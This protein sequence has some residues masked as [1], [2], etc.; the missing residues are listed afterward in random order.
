M[1]LAPKDLFVDLVGNPH[2]TTMAVGQV[3]DRSDD[4]FDVLVRANRS[5]ADDEGLA[6][7]ARWPEG[8][9]VDSRVADRGI[10]AIGTQDHLPRER[11]EGDEPVVG[12]RVCDLLANLDSEPRTRAASRSVAI[13]PDHPGGA[14]AHG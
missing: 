4:E 10:G 8:A 14:A 12:Q 13:R 3:S 11:R 2:E 6:V 7:A 1:A 5:H 9:K